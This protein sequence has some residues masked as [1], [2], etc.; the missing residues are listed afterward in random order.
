MTK[1]NDFTPGKPIRTYAQ[2]GSW[3]DWSTDELVGAKL[4]Y[5]VNW[6]C[7]AELKFTTSEDVTTSP[8]VIIPPTAPVR[9]TVPFAVISPA[10]MIVNA[11]PWALIVTAPEETIGLLS[12]ILSLATRFV[13]PPEI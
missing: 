7:G 11:P 5:L 1:N 9:L 12:Q 2:D 3:R 13:A 4:N 6:K 8:E 10:P